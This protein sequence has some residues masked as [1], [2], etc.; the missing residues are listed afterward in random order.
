LGRPIAFVDVSPDAMYAALLDFGIP[1]WQADGL[2]E[3]Y[4]HYRRC[5]AAVVA[6]VVNNVVGRTPRSFAEFAREHAAA[7]V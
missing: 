6:P 5:E 2:L 4:A 1:R 3:D 7:F